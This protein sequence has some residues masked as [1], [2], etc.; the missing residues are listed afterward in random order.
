MLVQELLYSMAQPIH[1]GAAY[2]QLLL[3]IMESNH[4]ISTCHEESGHTRLLKMLKWVQEHYVWPGI[5]KN[6]QGH[7]DY[8]GL[9]Q[10]Y[11]VQQEVL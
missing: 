11:T 10:V 5:R 2:R 4:I 9:C 3:P 6:L 1:V 8:C 7:L